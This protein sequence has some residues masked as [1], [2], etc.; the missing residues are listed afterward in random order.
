MLFSVARVGVEPTDNHEGLSFAALPFA[1]RA[2][3]FRSRHCMLIQGSISIHTSMMFCGRIEKASPMGFEP[4]IS[5]VTGRRALR[6]S[7]RTFLSLLP[8]ATFFLPHWSAA[9]LA[10][11]SGGSRTHSIPGSKPRWST[12]CLPSHSVSHYRLRPLSSL[13][14][15]RAQLLPWFKAKVV[16]RLPTEPFE[17]SVPRAG[18]E[19]A[20]TRV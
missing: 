6:C 10:S 11:G 9:A 5:C 2:M 8:R 17:S 4:T 18:I 15:R 3:C 16:Y 14:G 20:N 7:A 12:D 19:P 1:Y 13:I